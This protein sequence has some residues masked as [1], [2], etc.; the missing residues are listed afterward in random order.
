MKKSKKWDLNKWDVAKW[1]RNLLLFFIPLFLV[2]LGQLSADLDQHK[3]IT[4]LLPD[5][6]TIGALELYAINALT[7]LF[8]KYKNEGKS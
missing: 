1:L 3:H 2:Y 8:L 4:T 6:Q 7:D 5:E